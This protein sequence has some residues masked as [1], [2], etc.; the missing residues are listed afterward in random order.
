MSGRRLTWLERSSWLLAA[1]L[2]LAMALTLM[3]LFTIGVGK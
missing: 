2:M 1:L 3:G